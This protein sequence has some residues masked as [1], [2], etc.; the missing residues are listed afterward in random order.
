MGLVAMD[1]EGI[2]IVKAE[3]TVLGDGSGRR[4]EGGKE[5]HQHDPHPCSTKRRE[6]KPR[7]HACSL[8][9]AGRGKGGKDAHAVKLHTGQAWQCEMCASVTACKKSA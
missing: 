7:P 2:R 4:G 3:P 6:A 5:P 9:R 1:C 8:G